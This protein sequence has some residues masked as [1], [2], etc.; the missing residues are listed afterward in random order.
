[1]ESDKKSLQQQI[2]SLAQQNK[3]TQQRCDELEQ[4]GRGHYSR[5]HS[6]PKQNNEKAEGF[7]EFVKVLIEEV[8]HL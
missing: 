7:F 1:M 2:T 4:H 3:E 5:I 6:V 8:L